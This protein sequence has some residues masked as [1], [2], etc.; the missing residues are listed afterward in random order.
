ME[1]TSVVRC[2]C[3]VNAD[4]QLKLEGK[5]TLLHAFAKRRGETEERGPQSLSVSAELSE[6]LTSNTHPHPVCRCSL[7]YGSNYS[8]SNPAV[9]AE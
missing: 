5:S 6:C 7:A 8:T 2:W 1:V 9:W 4:C 3:S